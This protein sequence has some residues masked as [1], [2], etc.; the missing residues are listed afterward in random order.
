[1]PFGGSP[2]TI[3]VNVDPDLLRSHSMTPDQIVEAIR[4]NNQ[5]AP[6]G[7]VRIGDKNYITPTNNTIKEVKDFENIPLFKG[8]VQNLKL[9]DVA[10]VKDGADIT[11]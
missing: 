11:A 6:S 7:N 9:G 5:T 8:S 1:A 3:E 2:R 4:V 10:T